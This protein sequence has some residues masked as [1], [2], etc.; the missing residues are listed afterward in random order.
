MR[1]YLVTVFLLFTLVGCS[2]HSS[3]SIPARIFNPDA[4]ADTP[5]A[6]YSSSKNFHL[7]FEHTG[8][9]SGTTRLEIIGDASSVIQ[10]RSGGAATI[11]AASGDAVSTAAGKAASGLL[12]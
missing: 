3:I 1:I 4:P 7:V 6:T 5:P 8:S 2:A 9:T 11:I 10:S 12:R